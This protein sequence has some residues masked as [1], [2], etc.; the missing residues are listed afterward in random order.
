[1][2]KK[3]KFYRYFVYILQHFPKH[4]GEQLNINE[5]NSLNVIDE[6]TQKTY[7]CEI[8]IDRKNGRCKFIGKGWFEFIV[9]NQSLAGSFLMFNFEIPTR[10]LYVCS[11]ELL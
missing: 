2:I 9:S 6:E 7:V 8:E 4:V 1:M 11:A 10:R 3:Q 5:N